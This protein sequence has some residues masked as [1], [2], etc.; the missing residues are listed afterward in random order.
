MKRNQERRKCRKLSPYLYLMLELSILAQ[1]A[2]IYLY[3]LGFDRVSVVPLVGVAL[4]I[5][6]KRLQ[7]TLYVLQRCKLLRR[8]R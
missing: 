4:Y 2:Y 5:T 3:L 6:W 7:R 1:A 8:T